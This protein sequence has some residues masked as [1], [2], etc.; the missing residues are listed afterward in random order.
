MELQFHKTKRNHKYA[1][2]VKSMQILFVFG[3][4]LLLYAE[5]KY[6][7][8]MYDEIAKWSFSE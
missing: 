1:D 4:H 5:K 6:T 3:A 2:I 8:Q 7:L